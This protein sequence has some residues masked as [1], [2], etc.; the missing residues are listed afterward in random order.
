V[1]CITVAYAPSLTYAKKL[2]W[3]FHWFSC[4]HRLS[5]N[6]GANVNCP[7]AGGST[8][9]HTALSCFQPEADN[10]EPK[11]VDKAKSI[12]EVKN[13]ESNFFKIQKETRETYIQFLL[14]AAF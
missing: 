4:I 6:P 13:L 11:D 1:P 5:A 2:F 14:T 3:R 12:K 8:P 9:L 10:R 7:D